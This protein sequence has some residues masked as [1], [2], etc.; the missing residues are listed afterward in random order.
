[1]R[2]VAYCLLWGLAVEGADRLNG[3]PFSTLDVVT[4]TVQLGAAILLWPLF[5]RLWPSSAEPG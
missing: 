4:M 1:M 5:Q 2:L 3:D